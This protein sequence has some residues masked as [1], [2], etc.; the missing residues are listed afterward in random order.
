MRRVEARSE[1]LLPGSCFL[2]KRLCFADLQIL[3]CVKPAKELPML[4]PVDTAYAEK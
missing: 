3:I 1:R 4:S 2:R